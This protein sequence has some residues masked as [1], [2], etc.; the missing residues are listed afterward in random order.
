MPFPPAGRSRLIW[1]IVW[2]HKHYGHLLDGASDKFY[3]FPPFFV[4][5]MKV[6]PPFL[7]FKDHPSQSSEDTPPY[8]LSRML[9]IVAGGGMG[10]GADWGRLFNF[11]SFRQAFQVHPGSKTVIAFGSTKR[12]YNLPPLPWQEEFSHTDDPCT[13][14]IA[15]SLDDTLW[16]QV[17]TSQVCLQNN[18]SR[19]ET[20]GIQVPLSLGAN[21]NI[22]TWSTYQGFGMSVAHLTELFAPL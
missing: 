5:V 1:S 19:L 9:C 22:W 15:H 4:A 14:N 16:Q 12:P 8:H 2:L 20:G 3:N 10:E 7:N 18:S 13:D 11:P 17:L 21:I 6:W